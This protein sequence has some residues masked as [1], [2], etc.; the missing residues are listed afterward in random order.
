M[1]YYAALLSIDPVAEAA[2]GE[3]KLVS[4]T[5]GSGSSVE[6]VSGTAMATLGLSAATGTGQNAAAGTSNLVVSRPADPAGASAA[7]GVK[8]YLLSTL[9]TTS[10]RL[11]N[12]HAT[13]GVRIKTCVVGDLISD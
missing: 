9:V 11:T 12:P 4:P 8:A 10:I 6:V 1:N 13:N 2:A 7:A 3:M 5:V